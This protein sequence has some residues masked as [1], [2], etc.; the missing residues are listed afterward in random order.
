MRWLSSLASLLLVT[1]LC[2]GQS[3]VVA[4]TDLNGVEGSGFYIYAG[5]IT[6]QQVFGPS[7]LAGL[8]PGRTITGMQLRLD[9]QWFESP[10]SFVSNFDVSIGPSNFAPGSLSDSVTANQGAGTVL[11][12]SGS[13]TFAQ[14]S[15]TF[16][17]MPNAFGPVITFTTPYTYTGGNLLIT[18][19]HSTPNNEL[20]FDVG[21]GIVGAQVKQ[22]QLYGATTLTDAADDTGIAMQFTLAA[23]PEPTTYMMIGLAVA[24]SG[25]VGYR[26]WRA[27]KKDVIV[28][29]PVE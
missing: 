2:F 1:G 6:F 13:L 3:T 28:E 26:R 7:Q 29:Q 23:V 4:P 8:T 16:G 12:R 25:G 22:A 11:A 15:F 20:D 24:V 18:V 17:D 27:M 5:P 21:S 19:S 9:F 14:D 10:A